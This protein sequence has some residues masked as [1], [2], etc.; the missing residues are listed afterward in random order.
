MRV[1]ADTSFLVKLLTREPGTATAVAE[2]R[3]LGRPAVFF[4]PLHGL[5]VT[6][7]IRQKVFHQR[8]T[9]PSSERSSIKRERDT[10]LALLQKYISRKAFIE[11]TQDLEVAIE[12]ARRLSEKYTE[13]MGCRGFDLLH[14]ALALELEC[15]TF[16]TCDGTQGDVAN[17][18]GM[19]VTVSPDE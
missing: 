4:V 3:R 16:L 18:E 10:A 17:A 9:L 19:K 15:E 1:Y 11:I 12:R 2:Y 8:R 6:N 14:V 7:A 5:E 13:Q